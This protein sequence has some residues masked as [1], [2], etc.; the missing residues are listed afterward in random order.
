LRQRKITDASVLRVIRSRSRVRGNFP[1]GR[2]G[3]ETRSRA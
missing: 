3:E 2:R 1:R